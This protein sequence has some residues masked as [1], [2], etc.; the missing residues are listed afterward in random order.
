MCGTTV[1]FPV[2]PPGRAASALRLKGAKAAPV[3]NWALKLPGALAFLRNFQHWNV[4]GQCAVPFLIIAALVWTAAFVKNKL[5][6]PTSGEGALPAVQADPD[7][8]RRMTDLTK[9]EKAAQD[10]VKALNQAN[11]YLSSCELTRKRLEK[12]DPAQK[13]N[14]DE[15]LQNAQKTVTAARK[16]FDDANNKYRQLGGSVDYY[17]QLQKY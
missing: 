14:A 13:K 4:V 11:A 2:V 12:A 16:Q 6:D 10:A 15:L 9:A 17:S 8:W 3:R 5:G 1:T 7:A